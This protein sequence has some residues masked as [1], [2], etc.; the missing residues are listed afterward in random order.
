MRL[1]P[2]G[3]FAVANAQGSIPGMTTSVAASGSRFRHIAES[4]QAF[5]EE[6][7]RAAFW[8]F[9]AL[10]VVIWTAV[11]GLLYRNLTLDLLEGIAHGQEWLILYWKHPPLPWWVD[12]VVRRLGGTRLWPFFLASQLFAAL[13]LWSVWR[14]AR[15][16][17]PPLQAMAAVVVLDGSIVFTVESITLNHNVAVLPFW[18]LVAWFGYRALLRGAMRDWVLLGLCAGLGFWAKYSMGLLLLVLAL[19]TLAEPAARRHL[20]TAGP[21][22]AAAVCLLVVSP[23]LVPLLQD[24]FGP[25]RFVRDRATEITGFLPRLD[26]GLRLAINSLM[27]TGVALPL[28]ACLVG[29]RRRPIADGRVAITPMTRRYVAAMAAGPFVLT[30]AAALVS[31][32]QMY[33][34]WTREFWGLFG[35]F[36][37]VLLPGAIDRRGIARFLAAWLVVVTVILGGVVAAQSFAYRVGSR[38]L[39]HLPGEVLA[40][41]VTEAWHR[42]TGRRLAII[43]GDDGTAGNVVFYSPDRPALFREAN[44][45]YSPWITPERIAR[46]GAAI[47]WLIQDENAAMPPDYRSTFPTA[48]ALEPIAIERALPTRTMR[49]RFGLAIVPPGQ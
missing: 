27:L 26:H 7:P 48:R 42:E 35:L 17:L 9:A 41:S 33:T 34:H 29:F 16:L 39:T 40:A 2:V 15:E 3:R 30:I 47:V 20:R 43:V 11:P 8:A 21:Y 28:Y 36:L 6:S 23:Q 22:V 18:S 12:D 38:G 1:A 31:G 37:V 24:N 13:C 14:F 25:F 44:P 10:H 46:E 4:L 45:V 19:Y 32:R 49:W 5:V